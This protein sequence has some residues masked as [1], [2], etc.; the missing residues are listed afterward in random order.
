LTSPKPQERL[1]CVPRESAGQSAHDAKG[2]AARV[3]RLQESAPQRLGLE[4]TGGDPR[5]VVAALGAGGR[6]GVVVKPHQA[7]AFANATGP[8]AQTARRAARAWAPGADAGRPA[9][10]PWPA[11]QHRLGSAPRLQAAIQAPMPWLTERLAARADA[12]APPARQS[13]L[14]GT[15]TSYNACKSG[16]GQEALLR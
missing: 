7:R 14:A 16:L 6:P 15:V 5:A 9:P 12:R 8:L 2:V 10:R 11:A 3:V 4:A 1:L 13:R